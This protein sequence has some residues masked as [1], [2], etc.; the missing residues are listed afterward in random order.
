MGT[1]TR[2][3]RPF[4]PGT[5]RLTREGDLATQ[6]VAGLDRFLTRELAYSTDHRAALWQRD[7]SSPEQ[8]SRS[9]AANRERF[10]R[11]IGAVDPREGGDGLELVAT[12]AEPALVGAGAGYEVFAASTGRNPEEER[13]HHGDTESTEKYTEKGRCRGTPCGCPIPDASP[14]RVD[15]RD[16]REGTHK[17]CPYRVFLRASVV[18]LLA[19]CA[20]PGTVLTAR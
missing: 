3:E 13:P 8:Y 2:D 11:I 14:L 6:M 4:L 16:R 1:N 7:F 19:Y 5:E 10:R 20:R 15:P 9:V 18:R 17:G 12:I